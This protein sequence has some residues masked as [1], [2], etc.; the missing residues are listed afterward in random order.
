MTST[1]SGL[2]IKLNE[3]IAPSPRN[4]KCTTHLRPLLTLVEQSSIFFSTGSTIE[5]S[6]M[7]VKVLLVPKI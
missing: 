7:Y 5:C 2:E 3:D 1:K 6:L 4:T